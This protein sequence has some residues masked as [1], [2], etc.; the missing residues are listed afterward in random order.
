MLLLNKADL[1]TENQRK[2]WAEYYQSIG[3]EFLFF[4]AKV[5]FDGQK[6]WGKGLE[7]EAQRERGE[8]VEETER[9]RGGCWSCSARFPRCL[10]ERQSCGEMAE[11]MEREEMV[12][13]Y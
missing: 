11:E 9:E 7:K 2:L 3:V 6:N 13:G 1:L 4:S 12:R 8:P 10:F 5:F